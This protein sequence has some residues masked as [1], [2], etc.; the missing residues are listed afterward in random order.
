[1]QQPMS[2]KTK[3]QIKE[4]VNLNKNKKRVDLSKE[5]DEFKQR[6]Q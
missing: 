2:G 4:I 1:M 6:I 3:K 5:F